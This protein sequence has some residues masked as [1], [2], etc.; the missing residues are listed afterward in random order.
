VKAAACDTSTWRQSQ[1]VGRPGVGETAVSPTLRTTGGPAMTIA[2]AKGSVYVLRAPV[3]A[4][5]T[6]AATEATRFVPV[7]SQPGGG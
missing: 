5:W 7:L 3:T 1:A 2:G 6:A 4:R